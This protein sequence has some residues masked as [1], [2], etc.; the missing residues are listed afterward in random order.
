MVQEF[1]NTKRP[2]FVCVELFVWDAMRV[3]KGTQATQLQAATHN[4]MFIIGRILECNLLLIIAAV[5]VCVW[6][7]EGDT[8]GMHNNHLVG[9]RPTDW[10]DHVPGAQ[11]RQSAPRE[12]CATYFCSDCVEIAQWLG[13]PVEVAKGEHVVILSSHCD[14]SWS[15]PEERSWLNSFVSKIW[16]A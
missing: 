3:V 15:A 13:F 7:T 8:H 1:A 10:D 4:K 6:N 2:I 5:C 16:V 9:S 11:S 12:P 14:G